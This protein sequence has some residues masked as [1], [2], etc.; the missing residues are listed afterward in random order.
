MKTWFTSDTHFF[1]S[2]VIRLSKRPF[3]DIDHMHQVFMEN[4]NSVV[5]P[6]DNIYVLGD[7]SFGPPPMMRKILSRLHG[8]KIL[9]M[10]NHDRKKGKQHLL[11]LGFNEVY[12]IEDSMDMFQQLKWQEELGFWLSHFPYKSA[13]ETHFNKYEKY[14]LLNTGIPLLCGHVHCAWKTRGNIFNVGVDQNN[15]TPINLEEIK[16]ILPPKYLK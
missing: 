16:K 6:N 3:K 1:H 12:T 7:L 11:N 4:W 2:N 15:Y 5:H 9:V 10:G 13:D 8:Y 14:Q